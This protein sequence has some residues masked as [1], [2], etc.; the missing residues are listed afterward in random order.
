MKKVYKLLLGA[1]LGVCLSG[2][3]LAVKVTKIEYVGYQ[4][5]DPETIASYLPIQIGDDCD[6]DSVNES[7][8]ILKRTNFFEDVNIQIKNSTLVV[9]VKEFPT[10]NKISFEGN[11]KLQDKE[12][13]KATKL[14]AGETLAPTK[15]RE[16]QQGMLDVYRKMGRYNATVNPKVIK[17][18]DNRVNLVFE[19]NEGTAAGIGRIVF[20]GNDEISSSD[21]RDVMHSK[22]KRWYRFFVTDD[23]YDPDRMSEDK[24][25]VEKYYHNSGYADARV[26]SAVAELSSDKK[27]FVLTFTVEEGP[28][29]RFG[30]VSVKSLVQRIKS[31]DLHKNL[32][33]KSGDRFNSSLLEVDAAEISKI[34]GKRGIAAI[35][36]K[37]KVIRDKA[38][39]IADVV[40]EI[41]EGDRIYIS[42][43]VINGNTKTRDHVIRREIPLEEGDAYNKAL[44]SLMESNLNDLEFFKKVDVQTLPDPNSPDK[45]VLQVEVEE[46]PTAEAMASASYSTMG[47]IGIDLTYN[48]KNFFGTGKA[49]S[50]LLGSSREKSGKSY[51]SDGKGGFK[52]VSRKDKFRF[53]NNVQIAVTDP[54]LFDKDI[55]GTIAGHRYTTSMWDGFDLKDLGGS[56]GISYN[57][58]Q[59]FM[60]GWEYEAANRKFYDVRPYAS[61]ITRYQTQTK[62]SGYKSDGKCN[63]SAVKH[64]IG[65][66]TRFLTGIRSRLNISLSTTF[67]GFGGKAKH[68]KNELFLTYIIA[69]FRKSTLTFGLS[70]GM[71]S[72]LGGRDPNIIDSFSLGAE[73]FRGFAPSGIGPVSETTRARAL[74]TQPKPGV[75]IPDATTNVRGAESTMR[76]FVGAKKYWKGTVE[77]GF[78]MLGL[79][80]DLQ[81]RGFV[82]SDFGTLWDPTSKGGGYLKKVEKSAVKR[83]GKSMYKLDDSKNPPVGTPIEKEDEC[84]FD[85][86]VTK[87]KLLDRRKIRMSIGFGLSFVSPFG[88]IKLTYAIPVKKE[89]YDEQY[90]FL[91]GFSTTF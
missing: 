64:T 90:R 17:L 46:A 29:Y 48:E 4:R 51:E 8:K 59:H 27:E 37:P 34:I 14:K 87:H 78:P 38:K 84:T 71:L 42:K 56:F 35:D 82:F 21:L 22:I 16:I 2:N 55:E 52:P 24:V 62:E 44:V 13:Y 26:I 61:P 47:G 77:Y 39:K 50:V 75:G 15:I 18:P 83:D 58:S 5:I 49:L 12:I 25:A 1:V 3:L 30:S 6:E 54:H 36:V 81:F 76:N 86:E 68:L 66:G 60:Q 11:D 73:S 70:T 80:E 89:K 65:Y 19:I 43:I 85:E 63:L 9:S 72:K 69:M 74:E 23:I 31:D 40:Y 79:P 67:A 88:P 28:L 91:V 41:I 10:I 33:A 53:L 45:C 32:Y 57:L 7:L 20:V